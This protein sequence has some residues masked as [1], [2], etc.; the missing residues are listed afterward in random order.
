MPST[1]LVPQDLRSIDF[2][3]KSGRAVLYPIY[4]GTY[5]RRDSLK[6]DTQD[7]TIF[8]RDHVLMWAKDMRRGIDYL[9]TRSD[10]ATQ[11]LAYYGL[12]WGGALG[13]LLPAI[14]PR[15]KVNIL[16]VAG[17]DFPRT[18]AEVDPLNFVT[19]ITVPTLMINGRFDFFFPVES[20]Q[21]PMF[22]RLGTP[23]SDKRHVVD[24][25]SHFVPRARLIQ[26]VLEWLDKYQPLPT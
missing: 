15:I 4:K 12:S 9:E 10:V 8:Y 25:G 5:Q 21:I 2:V 23:A 20:S 26:E 14:E 3:L 7:S 16:V 18:L 13:G 6:S 24:E 17:L 1:D 19:R 22:R 11:N